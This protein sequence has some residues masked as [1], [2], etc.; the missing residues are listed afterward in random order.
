MARCRPERSYRARA[1][2]MKLLV[3]S[4]P[5]S[6]ALTASQTMV[7]S[8]VFCRLGEFRACHSAGHS[9][10]LPS[11]SWQGAD[12]RRRDSECPREGFRSLRSILFYFETGETTRGAEKILD[13]AFLVS[14]AVEGKDAAYQWLVKGHIHRHGGQSYYGREQDDDADQACRAELSG[15]LAPIHE[16]HIGARALLPSPGQ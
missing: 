13:E 1:E 15:S 10:S 5:P 9:E 14:L 6:S 11:A 4:V 16:G 2:Y 3:P 8:Q 7:A 12:F